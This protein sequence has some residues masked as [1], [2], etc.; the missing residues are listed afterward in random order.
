[1][2]TSNTHKLL[3]KT[4][5]VSVLCYVCKKRNIGMIFLAQLHINIVM[6]CNMDDGPFAKYDL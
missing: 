5:T 4:I 3:I 2:K 6:H 1:M